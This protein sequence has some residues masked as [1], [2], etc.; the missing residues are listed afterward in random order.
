[1]EEE[2]RPTE[3]PFNKRVY[4]DDEEEKEMAKTPD[5]TSINDEEEN[6]VQKTPKSSMIAF[7][8]LVL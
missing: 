1:M 8:Y 2:K 5:R 4:D 3:Q 7:V 6:L